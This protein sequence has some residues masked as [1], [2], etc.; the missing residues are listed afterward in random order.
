VLQNRDI[1]RMFDGLTV[2][3]SFLLKSNTR[4]MLLRKR[5]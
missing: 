5:A 4:E 1:I 2:A 3:D